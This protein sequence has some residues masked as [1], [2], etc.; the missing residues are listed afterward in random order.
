MDELD[1]TGERKRETEREREMEG[2]RVVMIVTKLLKSQ[3]EWMKDKRM[4]VWYTT[5]IFVSSTDHTHTAQEPASLSDLLVC[6][7][8]GSSTHS[9]V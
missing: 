8:L 7:K 4:I 1:A 6:I 2:E 9:N 3:G 5:I